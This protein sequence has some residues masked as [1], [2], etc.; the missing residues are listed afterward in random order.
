MTVWMS[1]KDNLLHDTTSD[2]HQQVKMMLG[3]YCVG[4]CVCDPCDDDDGDDDWRGA[5]V[6]VVT[7]GRGC[8][9]QSPSHS[10][11]CCSG[12]R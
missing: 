10:P 5:G 3:Y 6:V 11:G 2:K 8:C 9:C 7:G 12:I 1:G 4:A